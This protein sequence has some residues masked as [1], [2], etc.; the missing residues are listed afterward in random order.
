MPIR[1][2]P[3]MFVL[4]WATGFIGAGLS[5]PYAEPL[6]FMAMRF[7]I[8]AVIMVLWSL[9]SRSIWPKGWAL[10]N[11]AIAGCL[12]HGIYLSTMFWAV[13]RGLPAGMAGL[14]SG[15]QPMI[16]MIM[17]ALVL[18]ER[19]SGRQWFGLVV[20]FGGVAMVVWPK[21]SASGG[22]VDPQTMTACFCAVLAI[23]LG[24]VW[25]KRFGSAGDLRSG[26]AVQYIA[27]GILCTVLAFLLETRE[28]EWTPDLIIALVWLTLA[29]SIGAIL[30][31]LV[32]IREG[33]IA[34]V[35]SLFYLVPGTA[36]I[37][38]YFV[39]GETLNLV[40]IIG[41]VVTTFGVAMATAR[42]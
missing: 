13:H 40:Q 17:A 18:G 25:Q 38:A 15:L 29:L 19:A 24:T 7:A 33:A 22:G 11:A 20:G 28:V 5:M 4:L 6:T 31:L 42:R 39:F 37:L 8:A 35:A 10:V 21:F 27:A 36:A 1:Y 23:S 32:L 34:K 12:I 41:M 2:Y 26:T 30:A 16:T 9:W 14:V 3:I